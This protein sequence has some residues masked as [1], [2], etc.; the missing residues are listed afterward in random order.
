MCHSTAHSHP[1]VLFSCL[2]CLSVY[3]AMDFIRVAH[4][5]LCTELFTE[6]GPFSKTFKSR[7]NMISLALF[8]ICQKNAHGLLN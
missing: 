4:K 5:S 1:L 6:H 7:C 3:Y 8:L 2:F